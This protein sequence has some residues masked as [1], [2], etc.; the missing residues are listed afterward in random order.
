MV[1]W[2]FVGDG[3]QKIKNVI[4]H[5]KLLAYL[6]VLVFALSYSKLLLIQLYNLIVL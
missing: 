3:I 1:I 6:L 5:S 4:V 2:G